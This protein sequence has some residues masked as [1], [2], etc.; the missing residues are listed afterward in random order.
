VKLPYTPILLAAYVNEAIARVTGREPLIPLAGVRM[1][2]KLMYFDSS[3]AIREL[4][5]PQHP[6]RD[7]LAKAVAWFRAEGY[8]TR[9]HGKEH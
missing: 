2:G 3:K 7:A 8:V 9:T 4:G 6:V 1:A 5:L